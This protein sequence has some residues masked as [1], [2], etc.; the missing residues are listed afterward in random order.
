MSTEPAS[1]VTATSR[2]ETQ[3]GQVSR[4]ARDLALT[5]DGS[6]HIHA[7]GVPIGPE[8]WQRI[9]AR[10]GLSL[11]ES[12]IAR[13]ILDEVVEADIASG[14]GISVRT[15]NAHCE[16]MYR[17]LLVH[18]RY[19]LVIRLFGTYLRLFA[20]GGMSAIVPKA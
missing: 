20:D 2:I 15:V 14:L 11:R 1:R 9:V 7:T 5:G 18:S 10:L 12:Q 4:R 3:E 6:V 8:E 19:Q 17:K 16:R 13:L